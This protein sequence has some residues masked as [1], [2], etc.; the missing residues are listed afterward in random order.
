LR[1]RSLGD[2][3]RFDDRRRQLRASLVEF[4]LECRAFLVLFAREFRPDRLAFEGQDV[5]F[6]VD[7][8]DGYVVRALIG[9]GKSRIQGDSSVRSFAPWSGLPH[10]PDNDPSLL[11]ATSSVIRNE[12][13]GVTIT[14][15]SQLPSTP[16]FTA[17]LS[18]AGAVPVA[19]GPYGL[20][21][22]APL[23]K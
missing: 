5:V 22:A 11:F 19:S 1:T 13:W 6:Q 15:P 17:V 12:I 4:A 20:D 2:L 8:T 21:H 7:R 23:R 14:R 3:V 16:F 18:S 10:L 9:A